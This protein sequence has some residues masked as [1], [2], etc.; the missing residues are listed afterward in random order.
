M[1]T[2]CLFLLHQH[3]YSAG[4]YRHI[5]HIVLSA[6]LWKDSL[7]NNSYCCTYGKPLLP[8][9]RRHLAARG[10]CFNSATYAGVPPYNTFHHYSNRRKKIDYLTT[11]LCTSDMMCIKCKVSLIVTAI[12]EEAFTLSLT[13]TQ[14]SLFFTT[15][16]LLVITVTLSVCPQTDRLSA[17]PIHILSFYNSNISHYHYAKLANYR[18]RLA[19]YRIDLL[20]WHPLL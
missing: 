2:C 3:A 6:L 1:F 7:Q 5:W 18:Q 15:S 12:T 8:V 4:I 16:N 14:S 17:L 9:P 19:T 10:S 20:V 11:S 13:H